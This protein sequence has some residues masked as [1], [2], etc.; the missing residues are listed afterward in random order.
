VVE[1]SFYDTPQVPRPLP[2]LSNLSLKKPV[3]I[4][5]IL[6]AESIYKFHDV[7]D[8]DKFAKRASLVVCGYLHWFYPLK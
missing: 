5:H 6:A 2:W 4:I 7:N 1:A 3:S 8:S